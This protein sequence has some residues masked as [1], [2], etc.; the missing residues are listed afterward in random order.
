MSTTAGLGALFAK[1]KKKVKSL[2]MTAKLKEEAKVEENQDDSQEGHGLED[3]FTAIV[4][5]AEPSVKTEAKVVKTDLIAKD[6]PKAPVE[7]AQ[8]A[9]TAET[10]SKVAWG[11]TAADVAAEV[12]EEEKRHE[13]EEAERAA[14]KKAADEAKPGIYVPAHLRKMREQKKAAEEKERIR[15]EGLT[16]AQMMELER[17]KKAQQEAEEKAKKQAAAAAA[18][19][20]DEE[21]KRQEREEAQRRKAELK[22]QVRKAMAAEESSKKVTPQATASHAEGTASYDELFAKYRGREHRPMRPQAELDP[23]FLPPLAA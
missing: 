9:E 22:A 11:K 6:E 16:P 12:E 1:K 14:A 13:H 4:S 2:N 8:A 17:K 20:A 18:S 5:G 15:E 19:A 21:K 7:P 3:N 10:E 23:C